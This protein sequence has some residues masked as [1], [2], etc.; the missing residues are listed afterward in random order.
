LIL[1][2]PL[3]T[4]IRDVFMAARRK[5]AG[6][7]ALTALLGSSTAVAVPITYQLTFQTD[8]V[9]DR[10]SGASDSTPYTM[11]AQVT[12]DVDGAEYVSDTVDPFSG[13]LDSTRNGQSGCPNLVEGACV[14]SPPPFGTEAPVVLDYRI[15]TPFGTY[16]PFSDFIGGTQTSVYQARGDL[17][18]SG[19][20]TDY[21]GLSHQQAFTD[22]TDAFGGDY[23]L[24]ILRRQLQLEL[25]G[26][27]LFGAVTDFNSL[28]SFDSSSGMTG[29][30]SFG[31][32]YQQ[33]HCIYPVCDSF[34]YLP[35]AV[36]V[37]GHLTGGSRVTNSVPEPGSMSLLAGGLAALGLMRRRRRSRVAV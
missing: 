33:G 37:V 28:T 7:V 29:Q 1:A 20:I 2:L 3:G 22:I 11:S 32:D 27:A 14:V 26:P 10:Y 19:S 21:F 25:F 8:L 36:T 13:N 5:T 24:T 16:A 35:G 34:M 23:T 18:G 12:W 31:I 9:Y 6:L 17:Y 4:T 30:I 15:E